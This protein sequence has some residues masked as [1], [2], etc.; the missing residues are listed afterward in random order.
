MLLV[1]LSIQLDVDEGHARQM[2]SKIAYELD[3]G[4]HN[5]LRITV[6][7]ALADNPIDRLIILDRS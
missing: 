1:F 5:G 7:I 4:G 6:D 2:I 3:G